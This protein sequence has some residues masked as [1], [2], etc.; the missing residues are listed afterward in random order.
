MLPGPMDEARLS[1]RAT[2]QGLTKVVKQ[3][4]ADLLIKIG[5]V[6]SA[7]GSLAA[8]SLWRRAGIGP[9]A[10]AKSLEDGAIA[11]VVTVRRTAMFV[12]AG[13]VTIALTLGAAAFER[14]VLMPLNK[15]AKLA[16]RE[17]MDLDAPVP[18]PIEAKVLNSL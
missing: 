4:A 2:R 6:P 13:D 3:D 15:T 18:R 10:I 17:L 7:G 1:E 8:L 14:D 12:P 5:W 11:E 16:R 9:K